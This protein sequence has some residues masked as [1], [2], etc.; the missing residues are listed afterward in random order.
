MSAPLEPS[1]PPSATPSLSAEELQ[2]L[3]LLARLDI[4]AEQLP[5]YSAQ[6]GQILALFEG[7]RSVDT[8]D[9]GTVFASY[10][11]LTLT[12]RPDDPIA[13][14]DRDAALAS[15]SRRTADYLTVPRVLGGAPQEES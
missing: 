6:L 7:L 4:P 13:S 1:T 14:L 15:S 2:H 5:A 11:D 12:P 3:A 10:S 8:N 9:I